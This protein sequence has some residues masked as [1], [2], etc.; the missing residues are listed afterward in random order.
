MK[1]VPPLSDPE[2]HTLTDMQRFH[3]S[4]RARMRAHGILLSHQGFSIRRIA[5]VYQVSRYAVAAWL[6]RWNNAGLVGLYDAPRPGRPL[7]LTPEE[8]QKV[9]QY[10]QEHPKELKRVVQRLEQDTNK[11][12][13]PKTIKRL[14]KK[15][16]YGWKRLRTTPAKSPEPEKYQRAQ[17]RI[18][19]LQARERAGECALWYFDASGFCL[20]PCI[21]YAWQP[22]G[23]TL[24]LP[25]SS[26]NQRLNVLGLLNRANMLVPYLIDGAVDTEVVVACLNQFSEQLDKKAYVL[27]DNAPV[28]R[29][30]A[31]IRHIPQWVKKGLIIKYLP[32]YAPEL[33]LIEILWRFMKYYWLPFSAY[34]SFHH[35]C[36]A[37]EEILKQ[38]GTTYTIDFQAA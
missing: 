6:E 32:S 26:H 29:S 17:A 31:F 21:P 2:I 8:Q 18:A 3:P 7:R 24:A 37:V 35:L 10:L 33:N 38:F 28:H 16:R 11:R 13:S 4:R 1:F 27:L 9:E 14:I 22:I 12:V 5:D 19:A 36:E 25:Q 15:K 20:Q 34:T 30:K 23:A